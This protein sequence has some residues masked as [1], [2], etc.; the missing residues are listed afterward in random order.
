MHLIHNTA[1]LAL[2]LAKLRRWAVVVWWTSGLC[3]NAMVHAQSAEGSEPQPYI[4]PSTIELKQGVAR[5]SIS[6]FTRVW[7]DE[8]GKAGVQQAVEVFDAPASI[9]PPVTPLAGVHR[10]KEGQPYDL[11]G[12]AMWLQFSAHNL[13]P[14]T[15]WLFQVE[16]PTTDLVTLFY[17]RADGSWVTQSAGDSLPQSQWALRSRYPLFNLS[18]NTGMPVTYLLRV[19][20]QRVPYSAAM[21]IYSDFEL[22]ESRQTQNLLLGGYFG[23]SLAVVLMCLVSGLTLRYGNYLRYATYVGILGLTQVAFLGLGAQYFTPE[24]VGWNSVSSFVMPTLSVAAALW[25][26]RALVQPG[27][28]SR[29]LDGWILLLITVLS[30]LLVI[31]TVWPTMLGFRLSNSLTMV[32]MLSLYLVLWRS[33]RLGDVNARW[34]ALGFLPIVLAGLFPVMRNFGWVSTGFLSQY[35]VTIGSAVEVPLLLFALIKRSSRQRDVLVREHALKQQDALTGLADERR[36][37]SKLHSSLLRARRFGHRLG[38]LH[39]CLANHVHISK[40]FGEQ[41][42]NTALLLTANQLRSICREIDMPARLEGQQFALLI[43]GP[44]NTARVIEMATHLLAQS[45]RPS[46]LLPVGTQAKLLISAAMLPDEQADDLSE[47]ATTQYQWLLTQAEL[48]QQ[49]DSK[50]AIRSLNF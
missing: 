12:K 5:V 3:G 13:Q 35:A 15:R 11:H 18:D 49:S 27:Q 20:H 9:A 39:V 14:A 21:H 40:E 7:I 16:L 28:F 32:A 2:S 43:E 6:E 23:M 45:L 4:S 17:Q 25:L 34:I 48:Q 42:A 22:I 47:D 31:E 10:R 30:S 26:V 33:T 24:A 36:F 44:V 37:V 8:S 38:I 1:Q 29:W 41:T 46:D 50:K 19:M